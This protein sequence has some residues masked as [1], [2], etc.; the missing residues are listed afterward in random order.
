MSRG[1]SPLER[2]AL[3]ALISLIRDREPDRSEWCITDVPLKALYSSL[4]VL[5]PDKS[6]ELQCKYQRQAIRRAL[7]RLHEQGWIEATAL[8]LASQR[9]GRRDHRVARGRPEA[10]LPRRQDAELEDDLAQRHRDPGR[11]GA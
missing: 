9:Q 7:G 4:Y 2:R 1:F 11:R 6:Y 3:L 10:G 5:A 8:A